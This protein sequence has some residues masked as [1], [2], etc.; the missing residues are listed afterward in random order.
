MHHTQT[1]SR[2][3]LAGKGRDKKSFKQ[4]SVTA[5]NA[6]RATDT[7]DHWWQLRTTGCAVA[8]S[9]SVEF[10]VGQRSTCRA[11]SITA[12]CIPRHTPAAV[13]ANG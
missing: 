5:N 10:A 8:R 12:H 3:S 7:Y 1:E 4:C 9:T 2:A 11:N 13:S 6:Q